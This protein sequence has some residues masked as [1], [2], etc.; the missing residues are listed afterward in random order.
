MR[1]TLTDKCLL[2]LQRC[3]PARAIGRLIYWLT[4][5]EAPWFKNA[6]IKGFCVL[7]PVETSEADQPVPEGYR[8]FN[9]FFTRE[10]KSGA[11]AL[12]EDQRLFTCPADGTLAHTGIARSGQL[13]QAKG[14]DYSLEALLGDVAQAYL[15]ANAAYTTIYLAPY[16]YHRLHMPWGG[17]LRA[18]R[19]IP[20]KLYSVNA[21]TTAT[22]P[23]LYAL[24]ER[25]VCDFDSPEGS[26]SLVFVGAMNVA[27][28]ST[29]WSGEVPAHDQMVTTDHRQDD[30]HLA[31][32]DYVGHFNM[33]STIVCV[34]PRAQ[35]Q[36]FPELQP[37]QTVF[38][39]QP[40]GR[41]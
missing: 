10:L 30:I 12:P 7:Y 9:A 41:L 27:S 1:A 13:L 8:H 28:M 39:G 16:N 32:G 18:T 5:I 38:M 36:W 34:G 33:G 37:S 6:F 26:F 17:K 11:R 31:R 20:G 3:I 22:L 2:F 24:N 23:G 29:A 35:L 4:R 19:F 21:R 25:L 14:V 40:L 15:L